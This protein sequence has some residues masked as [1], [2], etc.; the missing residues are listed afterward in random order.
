MFKLPKLEI[1]CIPS[2]LNTS[3][4]TGVASAL[5]NVAENLP[6]YDNIKIE[7]MRGNPLYQNCDELDKIGLAQQA[8]LDASKTI[9]SRSRRIRQFNKDAEILSKIPKQNQTK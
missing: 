4:V 9:K 2:Q 1:N 7:Q 3:K 6:Q 5:A 8:L